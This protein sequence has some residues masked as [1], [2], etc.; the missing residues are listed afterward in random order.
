[1]A[2]HF[3]LLYAHVVFICNE[4]FDT[5]PDLSVYCYIIFRLAYAAYVIGNIQERVSSSVKL[6]F[7]YDI[8]CKLSAHFKVNLL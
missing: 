1:M 4:I 2:H 8:A 3:L 6:H 5:E 7:I